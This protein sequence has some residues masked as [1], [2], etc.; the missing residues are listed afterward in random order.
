MQTTIS[1]KGQ[2]MIPFE[3]RAKDSIT[4]GDTFEIERVRAGVYLI[5]KVDKFANKGLI[6]WLRACPVKGFFQPI[7]SENTDAL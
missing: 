7:P 6:E 3:I 1:T 4:A 5:H 2:I